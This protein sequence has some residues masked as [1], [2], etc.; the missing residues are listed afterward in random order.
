M[1]E[2]RCGT[3]KWWSKDGPDCLRACLYQ[4]PMV[5]IWMTEAAQDLAGNNI[6]FDNEGKDCPTWHPNTT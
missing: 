5:P 3:C 4:A 1:A 2:R 6:M